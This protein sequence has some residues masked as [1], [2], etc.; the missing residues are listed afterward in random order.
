M[1]GPGGTEAAAAW[2]PVFPSLL[3]PQATGASFSSGQTRYW[4]QPCASSSPVPVLKVASESKLLGQTLWAH[5]R[6]P[7]HS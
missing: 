6:P 5:Q 3:G 1:R 7:G 4:P 2:E